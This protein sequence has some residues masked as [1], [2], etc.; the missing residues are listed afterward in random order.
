MERAMG[1]EPTSEAWEAPVLPLNY[2][3]SGSLNSTYDEGAEQQL[4]S[5]KVRI[6]FAQLLPPAY[7]RT[8]SLCDLFPTLS[9]GTC[10]FR[11]PTGKSAHL[12][13]ARRGPTAFGG[14]PRVIH[15]FMVIRI[16]TP[17]HFPS[18]SNCQ[19]LCHVPAS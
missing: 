10:R 4:R 17:P 12:T 19:L 3:R 18:F 6:Q 13:C 11:I 9:S 14:P 7:G 8:C 5:R 16:E 2:A 1:I 15:G